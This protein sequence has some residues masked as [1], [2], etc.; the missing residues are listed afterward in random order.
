M[1]M[2][3]RTSRKHVF[4]LLNDPESL[5]AAIDAHNQATEARLRSAEEYRK[6]KDEAL[7]A[8]AQLSQKQS[9]Y[10]E[11]ES[12]LNSR[13]E[14]L[15]ELS[16]QLNAQIADYNFKHKEVDDL[17]TELQRQKADQHQIL[18]RM[19]NDILA[20]DQ[21]A[22]QKHMHLEQQLMSVAQQRNEL[23][24]REAS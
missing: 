13:H 23:S 18:Q 6:A 7:T 9:E 11:R 4:D 21:D 10:N 3:R 14:A 22:N 12:N 1:M 24:K 2:G 16:G 15:K 8:L 19:T 17:K 20:K 5:K